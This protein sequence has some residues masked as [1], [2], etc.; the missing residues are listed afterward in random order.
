MTIPTE[1]A[2]K[3]FEIIENKLLESHATFSDSILPYYKSPRDIELRNKMT[4]NWD[5]ILKIL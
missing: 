2:K 4:N 3:F 1:L 5:D